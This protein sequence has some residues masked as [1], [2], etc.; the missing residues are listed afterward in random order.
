MTDLTLQCNNCQD[1]P[2]SVL[3]SLTGTKKTC[4]FILS[5]QCFPPAFPSSSCDCL[6]V[7][8]VKDA[9]I[10]ELMSVFL[11]LTSGSD[12]PMGS[13]NIIHQS[14][15][16]SRLCRLRG[17]PGREPLHPEEDI[18]G[19]DSNHPRNP[20]THSSYRGQGHYLQPPGDRGLAGLCGS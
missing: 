3:E 10:A 12:L 2:H 8:Q 7:I 17:G 1:S 13:A 15:W 16:T 4:A 20:T 11:K 9:T 5:D 19:T 14:P 6:A 18:R